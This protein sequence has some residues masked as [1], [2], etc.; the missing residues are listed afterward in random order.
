MNTSTRHAANLKKTWSGHSPKQAEADLL[1]LYWMAF[2]GL[3]A[4][5]TVLLWKKRVWGMLLNADPTGITAITILVFTA[6]TVWV[7]FRCQQLRSERSALVAA[8]QQKS[9]QATE[10][11]NAIHT[12]LSTYPRTD[13]LDRAPLIDVLADRLHGPSEFMWWV[14]GIQIKLGLLGKV[15]GFSI[16]A[17]QISQVDNFDP[18]QTQNLLK[19]LTGGLSIALLTTAVGL[20]GNMLL[21]FQLTRLDRFVDTLLGETVEFAQG[22]HLQNLSGHNAHAPHTAHTQATG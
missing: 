7:G 4:F 17:L 2:A 20:V 11:K 18:S 15:V 1:M 10:R 22:L 13:I 5:M 12:F 16:L 21:G 19:S 9:F 14:N 6:S 8:T 3:L